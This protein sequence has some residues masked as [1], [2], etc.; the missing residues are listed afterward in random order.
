MNYEEKDLTTA[1]DLKT[2]KTVAKWQSS[3]GE[4]GPHGLSLDQDAG[5]LFVACS[6]RVEVLD[7][8]H[9]G[10]QLSSVNT[11]NGVDDLNYSSATHMLYVGAAKDARLTIAKADK[12]GNLSQIATV[13]THEGARNGV[14]T[15][16]GTVYL[17]HSQLGKLAGLVVVSP[18]RK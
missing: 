16:D 7:V 15:R 10:E 11:G 13:P 1:I 5:Y 4:D 2:H 8:G 3:C 12:S 18:I 14:V 17:A 6:T 9:N